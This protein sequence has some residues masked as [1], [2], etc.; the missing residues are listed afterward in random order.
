MPWS[1]KHKLHCI[2]FRFV[3]KI[4]SIIQTSRRLKH[5]SLG[6]SEEL[7][8][9][10]E[11]W[12]E[13]LSNLHSNSLE[14]LHLA[15]VKEDSENYGIVDLDVSKFQ[16]FTCLKHLS[17]DYDHL[18]NEFLHIFSESCRTPLKSLIIHIHGVG[19]DHEKVTNASWRHF[20]SHNAKVEVT[21]N[22]IHSYTGVSNLLDIL[23]P[24]I[25]LT[26]FRQF[27]CS[28]INVPALG[29]MSGYYSQTLKS[30]HIVDGLDNGMPVE[31]E[32]TTNEDPFVMMA[33]RCLKLT[34]FTLIGLY[35]ALLFCD[36]L[37]LKVNQLLYVLVIH[38]GFKL[39]PNKLNTET[40]R[41][42]LRAELLCYTLLNIKK[43][44]L[45]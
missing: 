39:L 29:L 44:C 13:I 16:A 26:H 38:F 27:F 1:Y 9:H 17:I 40:V 22:L 28:N 14:S 34:Q 31:Y 45:S 3:Q 25:R 6:C 23:K 18:N 12:I 21:I 32:V 5:L 41:P 10:C 42:F 35:F 15:S 43:I 19:P 36:V 37:I 30:V 20:S 24:N 8:A 2:Y 11:N 7:L 4:E 33:W